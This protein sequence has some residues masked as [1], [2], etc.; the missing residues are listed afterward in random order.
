MAQH[1]RWARLSY[2]G[3]AVFGTLQGDELVVHTGDMFDAPVPTR[4]SIALS[5]ATWLTPCL[6]SKMLAMWNNFH[7][8]AKVNGWPEPAEPLYFAKTPNSFNA[9]LAPIPAPWN[10]DGRV[11][12]EGELGIVIGRTC[13]N[14]SRDDAAAHIFGYTCRGPHRRRCNGDRW[15]ALPRR[16]RPSGLD[17]AP[18]QTS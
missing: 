7:G 13:T 2:Q 16:W 9:H 10:Y 6:P 15:H 18:A 17:A 4:E 5:E 12:Y 1:T 3:R 11:M 14:V 8:A